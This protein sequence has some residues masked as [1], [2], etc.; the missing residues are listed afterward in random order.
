MELIK[1]KG[2]TYYIPAPTNVGIYV[3][4]GKE[5]LLIDTAFTNSQARRIDE[6]L[7]QNNLHPKYIINTHAHLDHCRGNLYFQHTYPGCQVYA[8]VLE[9]PFLENPS[10]LG[11]VLYSAAPLKD[12]DKSPRV[13]PVDYYME[14]GVQKI[15]D[16]K[17]EIIL[18]SGHTKGQI[19]IITPEKVCFP[20]DSIFSST[21]LDK[22]AIPYLFDIGESIETLK[23]LLD[24]DAD[25]FVISHD[26]QGVLTRDELPEL[27]DRNLVNIEK[28]NQQILE[29]LDQPLTRED[30]V[31][32]L[33]ILNEI[34][35]NLME[36]HLIFSTVSAFLKYL[37]EQRLITYSIEEGR[38]YYFKV[39]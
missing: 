25:Y 12:L 16:E 7:G 20:G 34:S 31:E 14:A 13:F 23:S 10:L 36:Y 35:L 27:V 19:G 2:K 1:V 8:S 22:Y 24:V 3:F 30:L 32:N 4:K 37:Y 9:K 39:H 6:L 21:I 18:L 17:F 29:L 15:N 11:A 33:V 38:F 5:C 28:V 26:E